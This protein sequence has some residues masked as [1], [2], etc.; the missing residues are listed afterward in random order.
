[1]AAAI[2]PVF[3]RF[4]GGNYGIFL[5]VRC[6]P[7]Y[8]GFKGEN[9]GLFGISAFS[10]PVLVPVLAPVPAPASAMICRVFLYFEG[11]ITAFYSSHTMG[12]N[13]CLS[14]NALNIN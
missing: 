5:Q 7:L 2:F 1:M 9:A 14:S 3:P 11:E 10:V 4:E 12:K 13:Q 8:G 6:L